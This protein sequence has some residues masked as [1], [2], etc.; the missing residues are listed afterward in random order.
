MEASGDPIPVILV[1]E[2]VQECVALLNP[3]RFPPHVRRRVWDAEQAAGLL[4]AAVR[5]LQDH[6][7]RATDLMRRLRNDPGFRDFTGEVHDGMLPVAIMPRARF[8]NAMNAA[9]IGVKSFVD[10]YVVL[11]A[12][13][14]DEK[15][16]QDGFHRAGDRIGGRFLNWLAGSVSLVRFPGRDKLTEVLEGHLSSWLEEAIRLRD[17]VVHHGGVKGWT[18]MQVPLDRPIIRLSVDD[19]LP[20]R[21]PDGLHPVEFGLGLWAHVRALVEDTRPLLPGLI[22]L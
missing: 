4:L 14:I 11:I 8:T 1:E 12:R 16:T 5:T 15:S 19:V 13:L 21:M 22:A 2:E 3:N 9:L 18:D 17:N 6:S 10:L 20:P 7:P